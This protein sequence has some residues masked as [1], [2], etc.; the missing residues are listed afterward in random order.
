MGGGGGADRDIKVEGGGG[1][2]AEIC[3][4]AGPEVGDLML[5]PGRMSPLCL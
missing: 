1:V 3:Q 2:V 4:R 5:C